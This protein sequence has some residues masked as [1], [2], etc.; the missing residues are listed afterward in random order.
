MKKK[1][2]TR[3]NIVNQ[4]LI[5][6]FILLFAGA[7]TANAQNTL[8]EYDIQAIE[9][10]TGTSLSASSTVDGVSATG[11]TFPNNL[12][13]EVGFW[14]NLHEGLFLINWDEG[15]FNINNNYMEFTVSATEG[16]E[17]QLD[18]LTLGVGRETTG[19]VSGPRIFRVYSSLDGY[20]THLGEV[21]FDV[22]STELPD[23]E[24]AILYAPLGSEFDGIEEVT[25]RIHGHDDVRNQPD[26]PG[27]G[28][29][30][31]VSTESPSGVP[32]F[33]VAGTGSNV[34]LTG[35]LIQTTPEMPSDEVDVIF[36]A[37]GTTIP[38]VA[39]TQE[40]AVFVLS[41]TLEDEGSDAT[42][43]LLEELTIRKS[44]DDEFNN[45]TD[46]I[47]GAVLVDG[48]GRSDYTDVDVYADRITFS[49]FDQA[50]DRTGG[51]ADGESKQ[52]ELYI[53]LKESIEGNLNET[54]DRSHVALEL[55]PDVD[56]ETADGSSGIRTTATIG[57]SATDNE[58]VVTATALEVTV[59][60]SA[61]I[62]AVI[63]FENPPAV[64]AVDAN[65][66]WSLRHTSTNFTITN[67][68]NITQQNTPNHNNISNGGINV[69]SL[70]FYGSG[71][72]HI[73]FTDVQN[74]L[75]V[76]TDLITVKPTVGLERVTGGLNSGTLQNGS[77]DQAIVGLG[78]YTVGTSSFTDLEIDIDSDPADR[79]E[80]IRLIK[81][82]SGTYA[83]SDAGN[84]VASSPDFTDGKLVFSSI[85]DQDYTGDLVTNYYFIIADVDATVN[86]LADDLILSV[87]V[88][89]FT[90]SNEALAVNAN[91]LSTNFN[92]GDFSYTFEG[93]LIE[94]PVGIIT[95]GDGNIVYVSQGVDT[96]AEGY[97]ASGNSWANALPKLRDALDWAQDWDVDENGTL[98]IW[99]AKGLYTPVDPADPENVTTEERQ[100]TFHLID[101]VELY[102]GFAGNETS[103]E[104]RD[105]E[106][107]LTILSGDIDGN[108]LPFDPDA[109]SDG[110][111]D[112]HS[113][114][115]HIVGDNSNNVVTGLGTDETA[116]IDGFTITS[117]LAARGDQY[118]YSG[119]GMFIEAG[120][121]TLRNIIF[122]GNYAIFNGGG[123]YN[124]QNS[125]PSLTNITFLGNYADY[126]GGGMYNANNSSPILTNVIFSKNYARAMG[127][128][129]LTANSNPTLTNVIFTANS[130]NHYDSGGG[131]ISNFE[132]SPTLTNV[133]FTGNWARFGGGGMENRRN[134]NPILINV[135]FSGN[136][137]D[138]G[139]G[140]HNRRDSNPSL[141]NVIIWG[142]TAPSG[143]ESIFNFE[144]ENTDPSIPVISH[145]LIEGS[146]GSGVDNWNEDVGTDGG[147]N[148]DENPLFVDPT[149]PAS[150]PA[151][152][153]DYRLTEISPALNVG[154]PNT[155]LSL[156]PGGPENPVDLANNP[157]VFAGTVERIDIGA[158]E[159]QGA[160]ILRPDPIV[161][162]APANEAENVSL[163]PEFEWE[164]EANADTYTLQVS[165]DHEFEMLVFDEGDLEDTT[166]QPG[167]NLENATTYFWRVCG[168]SAAGDGEWSEVWSF[169]TVPEAS[170]V[171][172]LLT[173]ANEAMDVVLT[174]EL[175]W[176]QAVGAD[177]YELQLSEHA[178]FSNPVIDEEELTETSF[179][180]TDAL[181]VSTLYYWQVRG[182]NPG[183]PGEW[184]EP[185]TF[186]TRALP[187][188][189]D[190]R[191]LVSNQSSLY[192]FN[193]ADFGLTDAAYSIRIESVS[194]GGTLS[195]E[196]DDQLTIGQINS[197]ALTYEP[198]PGQHGYGFAAFEFTVLDDDG[199]ESEQTYTMSIDLAA[200]SVEL[201]GGKG[202]RF[203]TSPSIGDTFEG[204]LAPIYV[205]GVPGSDNP[206]ARDA[207]LYILNQEAYQW[208][209]PDA[210]SDEIDPGKGFIVF[211]FE[212]DVPATLTSGQ[213][214]LPLDGEYGYEGL[215][216]DPDQPSGSDSH[217]LIAN[218]HPISLD[219]CE[220]FAQ[221]VAEN[222]QI[223]DP[224]FNEGDYRTLSC[225]NG[226][227]EIAPFQAFW[228][229]TLDS[230]PQLQKTAN[231]SLDDPS[232]GIPEAAYLAAPADGFF[233]QAPAEDLFRISLNLT[234]EREGFTNDVQI[235]FTEEGAMGMDHL[236]APKLSAA[237]LAPRWLNFHALDENSKGYAIR[238]LPANFSD[239]ITIPLGIETTQ[240]GGYTLSWE[241]P[242][243]SVFGG[244]YFL[245]D[246]QTG[247]IT[248]LSE[249]Q[250]Y[251]FDVDPTHTA[252]VVESPLERGDARG[253]SFMSRANGESTP[254]FEL[255][256]ARAGVDGFAGLGDLPTSITLNQNYP[257]PFNPTTII[258]YELPQT[259]QVRLDV[260]DMTGR[261]VAT[262]VNGQVAAGRHQVSFNAMNL[263]SGVYM[264][265]L[266][267]GSTVIS[268]QLTLIK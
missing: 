173:P 66:N 266:Q 98:Q 146:G 36:N 189:G 32:G 158:Y 258:S 100:A 6:G 119:G 139:G 70:I 55:T 164:S 116:I 200:T 81:A 87:D 159:F 29:L 147:N 52:Y 17:L 138:F 179:Q 46:I 42:N 178:D 68:I 203:L 84:V 225:F 64:Q 247:A 8:V 101:G 115:D 211:G 122:S 214:W 91:D 205:Q 238:S 67:T 35:T 141:T 194:G 117:G 221:A 231:L 202:W 49:G 175:T 43:V 30:A 2:T 85:S 155:N 53:W 145:S 265:R 92:T 183:G 44:D 154:D 126:G 130:A 129:M 77:T 104:N 237:G 95:P 153:G 208:E 102:G 188:A 197:D 54:I 251:R 41:F 177:T 246:T 28:G 112:T 121:P 162:T 113:Q 56:I 215:F 96:E 114:T 230:G 38:S 207:S 229:R 86:S 61:E 174:P 106:T 220:F 268:R 245:R 118:Q 109:D 167:E 19:N 45:W 21:V 16:N 105:W 80:N 169:T 233:K 23:F 15:D 240:A 219:F 140:I 18:N 110:D 226:G 9:G 212:D 252:K 256:V 185:F 239:Q 259:E 187:E 218:P 166:F 14:E 206:G 99:V 78:L 184:S 261:Q 62:H 83:T 58:V 262:L 25:F 149:D 161:L 82:A 165:T 132:S 13:V 33:T 10:F 90:F 12:E 180:I 40:D 65:G 217:F 224:S 196:V 234:E 4:F 191:V 152:S 182:V 107:N 69:E 157:R 137:A 73:V 31:N 142:N 131:G 241:L 24:Q 243:R 213:N 248:E 148:I 244:S 235:L 111:P 71:D 186:T 143:G 51:I 150:A 74:S 63:P 34:I 134:S 1:V 39:N 253:G 124:S 89:G 242:H 210:M 76:Q 72:T 193:G 160:P 47:A 127:G 11:I 59:Q 257:N 7:Y 108:D 97:N 163:Q 227:A 93:S 250:T 199:L 190:G 222:I 267:A 79:I 20:S 216:Y 3:H 264:Y 260:Y 156:F 170:E 123:M 128:G 209:L 125:N 75:S 249:G 103:L 120:S 37:S 195:A 254:R 27:G 57:T 144:S 172:I 168:T 171:V 181:D 26:F 88:S 60:P 228:I 198:A 201:T 94:D 22:A 176:N 151:T 136:S 204:F 48:D 223:W 5:T 50:A 232:L 135:T 133:T 263:S 192:I 236:D 255:L